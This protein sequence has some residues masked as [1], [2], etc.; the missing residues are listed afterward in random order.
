MPL[1]PGVPTR[2]AEASGPQTDPPSKKFDG[3]FPPEFSCEEV[4][5]NKAPHSKRAH[6]LWRPSPARMDNGDWANPH[7]P[8]APTA[9]RHRLH[10]LT[11]RAAA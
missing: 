5:L 9:Q 2:K 10:P 8:E 3:E 1:V 11:V 4:M 6:G 7:T